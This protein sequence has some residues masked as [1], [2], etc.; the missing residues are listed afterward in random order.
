MN[1]SFIVSGNTLHNLSI[2]INI[3]I[4]LTTGNLFKNGSSE[5]CYTPFNWFI[6]D[7]MPEL[8]SFYSHINK[9]SLP[10]FIDKFVNGKLD[11]SYKYNY[12]KENPDEIL[13]HMSICY[14]IDNLISILKCIDKNRDENVY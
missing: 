11:K 3:L 4:H 1:S 14:N 9:V 7:K 10:N 13:T 6:L 12:F 2:I 5:A 8:M